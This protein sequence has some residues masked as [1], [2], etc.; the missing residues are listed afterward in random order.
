[1]RDTTILSRLPRRSAADS[2]IEGLEPGC[3]IEA[4]NVS[5][6]K[7][8]NRFGMVLSI[9]ENYR[10]EFSVAFFG[11]DSTYTF[12]FATFFGKTSILQ[13][14]PFESERLFPGCIVRRGEN[15]GHEQ[16]DTCTAL[17]RLDLCPLGIVIDISRK[18][19]LTTG[20]IFDVASVLWAGKR[21]GFCYRY[22]VGLRE[23]SVLG[24]IELSNKTEE[25]GE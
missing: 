1:M 8:K 20:K 17:Y 6:L 18:H 9:P 3:I 4:Q 22:E 23:L 16:Q 19:N 5:G 15:W 11:S 12:S 7:K 25:D 13:L 2:L 10:E 21:G 24:Y 14:L